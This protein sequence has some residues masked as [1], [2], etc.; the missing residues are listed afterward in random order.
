MISTGG[1][2][3]RMQA[4]SFIPS[5]LPGIGA[6][7]M[8]MSVKP[9]RMSSRLSKNPNRFFRVGSFGRLEAG[10]L[11]DSYR[12]HAHDGLIL[13]NKNYCLGHCRNA[14]SSRESASGWNVT[15]S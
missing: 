1:Q 10:I 7:H 2:R 8:L 15:G 14:F 5:M 4:A 9:I 12:H 6:G 13:H 11:D 3:S